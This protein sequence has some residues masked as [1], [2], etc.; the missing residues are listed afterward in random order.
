[1]DPEYRYQAVN[2]EAQQRTPT[3]LL[4]WMRR[5]IA[6]RKEH[7]VFGLGDIRCAERPQAADLR[8]L[9]TLRGRRVLVVDNLA[10]NAQYVELDLSRLR[11]PDPVAML[12]RRVPRIG[13][14]PY[15]LTLG[16]TTSSGSCSTSEEEPTM[17]ADEAD[18]RGSDRPV[19]PSA[20]SHRRGARA[21]GSHRPA[22]VRGEG[23]E[24]GA[25]S[26]SSTPFPLTEAAPRRRSSRFELQPE[27]TTSTSCRS[28]SARERAAI[29]SPTTSA[30]DDGIV[31]L[32]RPRAMSAE[33]PSS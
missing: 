10:R 17:T 33:P 19:T 26:R 23:R 21:S 6:L 28:A 3:S 30:R 32:R 24:L 25:V 27:R 31:H 2:V 13:E 15:L 9:R 8:P 20:S 14:L 11:G 18:A 7:P 5:L 29:A 4:W 16:R 22:L 1:M 12:G